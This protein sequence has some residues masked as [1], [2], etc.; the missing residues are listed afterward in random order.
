MYQSRESEPIDNQLPGYAQVCDGET[1][2]RTVLWWGFVRGIS[3]AVYR[4]KYDK[5][6]I[7]RPR[8]EWLYHLISRQRDG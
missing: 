4:V 5:R 3:A 8:I 2:I 7:E 1:I 6:Y